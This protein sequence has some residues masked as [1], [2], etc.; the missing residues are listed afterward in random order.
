MD[1]T[2]AQ[3]AR[4][5]LGLQQANQIAQGLS[6]SLDAAALA[7]TITE[8]L[9][10]TFQCA[11]ARVWVVEPDGAA[12]RLIA[13]S[14][15]YTRTDGSFARVP[16]GAFKV[17]KIAQ[18]R[19]SFLSNQLADEPWVKDRD[20]AIANGIQG[21]A[22]YPLALQERVVG[23]LA[24]FSRQA[25][26]PEFLEVLLSLS[27]TLSVA[28]ELSL[29]HERQ[30]WQRNCPTRVSLSDQLA[31]ILTQRLTLVGRERELELS[32]SQL[33]VQAAER[34]YR[35]QCP[36]SRLVYDDG[37]VS[38]EGMLALDSEGQARR[39]F[40]DLRFDVTCWGG[41]LT[42]GAAVGSMQIRVT[43]PYQRRHSGILVRVRCR[44]P[45]LEL[46]FRQL[47]RQA[48]VLVWEE[49]GQDVQTGDVPLIT[50][51][52]QASWS[53]RTVI[54]IQTGSEPLP[55]GIRACVG[56]SV[57]PDQL[58]QAV[59]AVNRGDVWGLKDP[60]P[61]L[62][63]SE[64]EGEVMRLLA[65]GHRDREIAQQLHISESTIK[66]HIKNVLVKLKAR[67]RFQAL[68]QLMDPQH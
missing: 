2:S 34:L 67:T 4:L 6:G 36:Y 33:L 37:E 9:V 27:T 20:W 30:L 26:D 1:P 53:S 49:E 14:G 21:F 11:F 13:S 65:Q 39:V 31:G 45:V 54:W 28:L 51:D 52:R 19:V 48:G 55:H 40:A 42:L 18:N 24:V 12:L 47:A 66:F 38:L 61:G 41:S 10:H 3:A 59:E 62:T 57:Q 58:R 44:Q 17:G 7:K 43:L 16:L 23:V 56:L 5:L 8:G 29:H 60:L 35:L 32:V 63:L 64:R 46:A 50:D 25:M 22:G 68:Y 15:L